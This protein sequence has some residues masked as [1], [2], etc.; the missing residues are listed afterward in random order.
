MTNCISQPHALDK[1]WR[2]PAWLRKPKGNILGNHL[3]PSIPVD[4]QNFFYVKMITSTKSFKNI[5]YVT[6][7]TTNRAVPSAIHAQHIICLI[8]KNTT[9]GRCQVPTQ[10]MT[11]H[12]HNAAT[13]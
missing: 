9:E 5:I 2:G 4:I 8:R 3:W 10:A 7:C 13:D 1:N 11:G 6:K 12:I